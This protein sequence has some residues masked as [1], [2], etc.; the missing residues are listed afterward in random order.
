MKKKPKYIIAVIGTI[1]IIQA[2]LPVMACE[3]TTIQGDVSPLCMGVTYWCDGPST[4]RFV[5]SNTHK[6]G[7][8]W[9][10]TCTKDGYDCTTTARCWYCGDKD[11]NESGFYHHCFMIHSACGEGKENICIC[12]GS[13]PSD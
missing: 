11:W 4:A 8:A 9:Q 6:Y 10:K 12:D 3:H 2:S 1:A 13:I 7:F 5:E